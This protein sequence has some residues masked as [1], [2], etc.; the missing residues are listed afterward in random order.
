MYNYQRTATALWDNTNTEKR[1]G[2][3]H[4]TS[5]AAPAGKASNT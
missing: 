2:K 4:C 1:S 5:S 3:T